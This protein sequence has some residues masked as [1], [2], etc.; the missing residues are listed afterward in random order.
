MHYPESCSPPPQQKIASVDCAHLRVATGGQLCC[1]VAYDADKHIMPLCFAL[2]KSET[3]ANWRAFMEKVFHL[4]PHFRAIVSDGSK[5]LECLAALFASHDVLHVRCAW[6]I[7]EK[8]ANK[9]VP[10]YVPKYL[11][12]IYLTPMY[13]MSTHLTSAC[14][15]STC[16]I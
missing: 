10:T 8:N 13:L 16:L 15:I 3:A 11:T 9:Q 1:L 6:H 4:F 2:F 12:P 5:G 14:L 7:L